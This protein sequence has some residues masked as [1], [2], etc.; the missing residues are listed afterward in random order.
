MI[1]LIGT[2]D[3]CLHDAGPSPTI[4]GVEPDGVGVVT[5]IVDGDTLRLEV[6]GTELRVRLIGID[7]PEV[8]PDIECYGEEAAAALNDLAPPGSHLL[9]AYDVEPRDRYDREL[10]YLYTEAGIF[11]NAA[12][13]ERG[14]A[15]A[16]TVRP[17]VRHAEQFATLERNAR[18]SG[19]GLWSAC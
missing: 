12:L 17:N 18:V 13:V 19:L 1:G 2:L 14:A 5:T 9:F 3:G 4:N 10:L 11:I 8:F 7:T 6:D 15:T 16:L